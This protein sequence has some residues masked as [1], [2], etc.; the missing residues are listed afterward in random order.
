MVIKNVQ[1]FTI[2]AFIKKEAN[3]KL[4][5]NKKHISNHKFKTNALIIEA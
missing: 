3:F 2:D 1:T 5:T 4:F